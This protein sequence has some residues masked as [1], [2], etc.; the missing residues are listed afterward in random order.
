VKRGTFAP[1]RP[2]PNLA[3][4]AGARRLPVRNGHDQLARIFFLDRLQSRGKTRI[5]VF[6]AR[7]SPSRPPRPGTAPGP[8]HAPTVGGRFAPVSSATCH[9]LGP[10][11]AAEPR[12]RTR[13]LP[14]RT[15]RRIPYLYSGQEP[16][17]P[18]GRAGALSPGDAGPSSIRTLHRGGGCWPAPCK[19]AA[20]G[21]FAPECADLDTRV[22]CGAVDGKYG[23]EPALSCTPFYGR[24]AR[25]LPADPARAN[26]ADR[27]NPPCPHGQA[28]RRLGF[29]H[30]AHPGLRFRSPPHPGAGAQ[31]ECGPPRGCMISP[32]LRGRLEALYRRPCGM[33]RTLTR[34]IAGSGATPRQRQPG[35]I[36]NWYPPPSRR[37]RPTPSSERA[38]LYYQ[39]RKAPITRPRPPPFESVLHRPT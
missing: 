5:T 1:R 29:Q 18:H 28:G 7:R 3:A 22:R 16:A 12:S 31:P 27:T 17:R 19:S 24:R 11:A 15:V 9:G 37:P 14:R 2:G 23:M 32:P 6:P 36:P 10:P 26:A 21:H 4:P 35:P 25:R 34:C 33:Q 8:G 20:R 30:G 38:A 13:L 39:A